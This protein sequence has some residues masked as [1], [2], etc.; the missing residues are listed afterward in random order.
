MTA[1]PL[2]RVEALK[3]HLRTGGAVVKAVD[4]VDLAVFPGECV[5]IVG[6]SGSGKSTLARAIVRLLPNVE[7][8]ELSGRVVFD[9]ADLTAMAPGAVRRLRHSGGF[10]M[11][12]QDPLSSLNPTRRIGVQVAEAVHDGRS[13]G[14]IRTRV[15]R[16]LHEVGLPEP[17]SIARRYPHELS[18]GMRQRAMIAIALASSPKLLVADEPTSALDATVQLRVLRTLKRL[19]RDHAM[20][21]LLVTHDL[22][23]VAQ[24]CDRVYVMRSGRVVEV[25]DRF[26]LF[27]SPRDP[28]TARLITLSRRRLTREAA[29]VV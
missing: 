28:Y 3:V 24:L 10:S 14:E 12:F 5:G 18:G 15:H 25:A 1:E 9:G 29:P 27:D 22:G 6:E 11:V 17:E 26:T 19:H 8:A 2:L 4:G 13:R 23:V 7:F 16:L 21:L 20:A